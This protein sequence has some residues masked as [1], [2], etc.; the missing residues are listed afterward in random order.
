MSADTVPFPTL[1]PPLDPVSI[2]HRL[3][4]LELEPYVTTDPDTGLPKAVESEIEPFF[5]LRI[6]LSG[7][8]RGAAKVF[9]LTGVQT[10]ARIGIYTNDGSAPDPVASAVEGLKVLRRLGQTIMRATR[11]VEGR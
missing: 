1:I 11:A 4:E 7:E 2:V 10:R 6:E 5:C 8:D 3:R 9:L